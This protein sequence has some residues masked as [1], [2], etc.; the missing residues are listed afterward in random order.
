MK[1]RTKIDS[2]KTPDGAVLDLFEHDGHHE[3]SMRG[4]GLMGSRQHN[5]EEEL[6]VHACEGH[7][8]APVVV[9]GGLGMGFTLRAALDALPED[10]RVVQVELV[11]KIVSWNRGPLGAH[12]G[13]PLEDERVKVVIGDVS[14]VIERNQGTLAAVMLDI[15]NGTEPMVRERNRRV[16][17]QNGLRRI[18]ASL[19]MGGRLAIWSAGEDPR[20][21]TRMKNSGFHATSHESYA[22]PGRKGARHVILLGEK[23]KP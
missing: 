10:A 9:I 20:M 1:P 16:Y 15:D 21:V 17:S 7:A 12:A 2:A 14:K 3:I 18:H 5:S 11:E 22:R 23:R 6:A 13:H 8:D 4:A 19:R